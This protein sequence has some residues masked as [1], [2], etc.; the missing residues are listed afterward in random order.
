MKKKSDNQNFEKKV[1]FLDIAG[2]WPKMEPK[3]AFFNPCII[4]YLIFYLKVEFYCILA[5]HIDFHQKHFLLKVEVTVGTRIPS[6][7]KIRAKWARMGTKRPFY[8]FSQNLFH[9]SYFLL[10]IE[11]FEYLKLLCNCLGRKL[12]QLEPHFFQKISE[13][14]YVSQE[15]NI[16]FVRQ[17]RIMN[18]TNYILL[19]VL[20]SRGL[21]HDGSDGLGSDILHEVNVLEPCDKY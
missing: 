12:R 9:F 15:L 14:N 20:F 10:D 8:L 21:R 19:K 3:A 1:L 2:T 6:L 4:F 7:P 17:Y 18:T 13:I 11:D 16:S 5:L